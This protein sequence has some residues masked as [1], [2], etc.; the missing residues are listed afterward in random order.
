M[1]TK[2]SMLAIDLTKG[3]FQVCAVAADGACVD[4]PHLA[5]MIFGISAGSSI[6]RVS[7]LSVWPLMTPRAGM[8]FGRP[9]SH[10]FRE[11]QALEPRD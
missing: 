2:I 7:G 3:S 1:T 11:L 5:S 10:R 8:L 9:G 6:G 4:A